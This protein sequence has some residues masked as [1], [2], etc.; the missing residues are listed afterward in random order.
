MAKYTDEKMLEIEQEKQQKKLLKN[1]DVKAS[2]RALVEAGKYDEVFV[3]YGRE[4]YRRFVPKK[5]RSED[6]KKLKQEGKY[7]DI[8]RGKNIRGN[9]R[10]KKS[11]EEST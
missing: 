1:K 6:F 10:G 7:E 4:A 2:I 9:E 11:N 5:V 8:Y 3:N